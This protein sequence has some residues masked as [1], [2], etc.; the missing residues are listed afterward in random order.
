M[1]EATQQL[2]LEH[3][4]IERVIGALDKAA[5]KISAGETVAPA[6]IERALQ[7]IR[8]FADQCH[9]AKEEA[10][11]FP[12]LGRHGVPREMGP[13]GVMLAD[14][15][16]GRAYVKG[17]SAALPGYAAGDPTARAQLAENMH[18]YAGLLRSHIAKEDNVLYPLSDRALSA[19]EK[20]AM[21]E[22]FERIEREMTGPGEHERHLA[23]I[24]ELEAMA[25]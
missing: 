17:M 16:Q 22:E 24:E 8:G 20:A 21:F 14:H 7:F 5:D 13:I 12:A 15:E 23:L 25:R 2:M 18:G 4:A 19:E 3:R 10:V 6:T 1:S 9:H 11:L